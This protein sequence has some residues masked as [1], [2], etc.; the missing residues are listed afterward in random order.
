M[1]FMLSLYNLKMIGV[2]SQEYCTT[3][4]EV[5]GLD[6]VMKSPMQWSCTGY[7]I[8]GGKLFGKSS[9][10]FGHTGWGGSM[11]FGDPENNLSFAYTMN[12]LTGSML[13]DQRALKLVEETYNCL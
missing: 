11:A 5:K 12:L 4:I 1:L 7:S 13:G 3:N 9:K 2:N 8:G 10:A 6:N